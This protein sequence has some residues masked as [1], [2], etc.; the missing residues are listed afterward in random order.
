[1]ANYPLKGKNVKMLVGDFETTVYKGQTNTEVWAS[2]LVQLYTEDVKILTSIDETYEYLLDLYSDVVVYYHNLKFDGTFWVSFLLNN[3]ELREAY[4]PTTKT[5]YDTSD[6]PLSTFKYLISDRGMWYNII[7]RLP[8]GFYVEIRDSLKLLPFSVRKIGKDFKTKHKK[9]EIEYTGYRQAHSTI[10][11]EEKDYISNDVLVVKEALELMFNNK[12]TKLTIGSCCMAEF[13][14]T[15]DYWDYPHLFPN[16]YDYPLKDSFGEQTYGS[17]IHKSYKGGWCYLVEA[18]A[19]KIFHNGLTADV[20]SLYPSVMS[21]ESGSVYPVGL[22]QFWVGKIPKYVLHAKDIYYFIRIRTKFIIKEGYLPFIQVKSNPL[23]KATEC[24]KTSDIKD[25]DGV[26]HKTY[27]DIYGQEQEAKVELTLTCTDYKLLKEHYNLYDVEYLDG[28]YFTA[29]SPEDIFDTY[30]NKWK[31]IKIHSEG[32]MRTLAKLFLNNLYGKM[33]T[34]I[35]DSYKH[36]KLNEDGSLGFEIISSYNGT[37]GYIAIG[38]AITSYARNF[39]IRAAQKNYHGD[40]KPGFIYADTDSIHCDLKPEEL[41]DVPVHDTDFCHWKLETYWDEAIFV[42]Q[43]TYIEHVTHEDGIPVEEKDKK[44]Y[45]NLKCAGMNEKCKYQ[46]IKS[47][48]GEPINEY[49]KTHFDKEQIKFMQTKRDLTDFKVGLS[50]QGKLRPK[51]IK[52]GTLLVE[53]SYVMR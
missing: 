33:A 43:K 27:I 24:L 3:T 42:R 30:I 19:N 38:S 23:Y 49:D 31:D 5:F 40:D 13:K 47:L 14:R 2:A 51:Q 46:F 41:I 16:L 7:I 29:K 48:T 53:T 26:Y 36:A 11:Q 20:N 10:S 1:M 32:A 52:G 18:K 34:W 45:Y 4:I 22:P 6:M 9:T 28:C 21:S 39:T 37:P 35:N 50:I 8:S 17:Y 12:H 25:K 15:I 44:P